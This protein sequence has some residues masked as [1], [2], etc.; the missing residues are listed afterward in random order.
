[1]SWKVMLCFFIAVMS[2]L[3]ISLPRTSYCGF[4]PRDVKYSYMHSCVLVI[5]CAVLFL[6]GSAT[7]A[8]AL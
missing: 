8:F 2:S 1:M 6:S 4:K 5:S 3:D 7:I